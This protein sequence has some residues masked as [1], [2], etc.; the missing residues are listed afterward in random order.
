MQ[1]LGK[2]FAVTIATVFCIGSFVSAGFTG[3][4]IL[5]G[6]GVSGA[7]LYWLLRSSGNNYLVVATATLIAVGLYVWF[8]Y[9][10]PTGLAL[11]YDLAC[12]VGAAVVGGLI[13]RRYGWHPLDKSR[14]WIV[15]GMLFWLSA[16]FFEV[17]RQAPLPTNSWQPPVDDEGVLPNVSQLNVGVSLSGGGFRAAVF[18]AGTLNALG[19]MGIR[20]SSISTVS[21]GSIIGTYYW[22]GGEPAAFRNAVVSG[23]FN[24]F[25]NLFLF[26]NAIRLTFPMQIYG[27]SIDLFPWYRFDRK[28]VQEQ[29]LERLVTNS[30][31]FARPQDGRPNLILN[32][33][34]LNQALHIAFMSDGVMVVPPNTSQYPQA[35]QPSGFFIGSEN[36]E[37]R[38]ALSLSELVAASGAFPGAFPTTPVDLF[39]K[40]R[41][42]RGGWRPLSLS[43]G[44]VIDN[45]G[46]TALLR[47]SE[48]FNDGRTASP[49]DPSWRSEIIIMSDAGAVFEA[50]RETSGL[51]AVARA[52][53][54]SHTHVVKGAGQRPDGWL[55]HWISVTPKLSIRHIALPSPEDSKIVPE[56]RISVWIQPVAMPEALLRRIVVLLPASL[57]N[58]ANIALGAF[59]AAN[60]YE[61]LSKADVRSQRL[62][63][64]YQAQLGYEACMKSIK[65][66]GLQ[67]DDLW[68]AACASAE[69]RLFIRKGLAEYVQVFGNIPTLKSQLTRAEAEAMF[70]LGEA[71]A[72]IRHYRLARAVKLSNE[73]GLRAP[74]ER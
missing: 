8:R 23:K 42:S 74:L 19:N 29:L 20:P 13:W 55:R 1:W 72:Y 43:D 24:L 27:T 66:D 68:R 47:A 67:L 17:V 57:R 22:R 28:D 25:R 49:L 5:L 36:W 62:F 56:A 4:L 61:R 48:T 12:L 58:E 60:P 16:S 21:G 71:L 30:E 50:Q 39:V 40:D 34:D 51:A 26:H 14:V 11:L 32:T 3:L 15:M 38:P 31:A 73:Q 65:A 18:H 45:L 64:K 63:P 53:D 37:I 10:E 59:L 6:L 41:V 9:G 7:L 52:F 70:N 54:V 44:G 46:T 69:L 35:S 2:M 33:T